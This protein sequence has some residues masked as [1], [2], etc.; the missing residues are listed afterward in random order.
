[1]DNDNKRRRQDNGLEKEEMGDQGIKK[2]KIMERLG[3]D[4]NCWRYEA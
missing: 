3:Q 2:Y 4:Y 1:M